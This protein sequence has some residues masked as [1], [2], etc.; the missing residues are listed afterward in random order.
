MLA[1]GL[2]RV[3]TYITPVLAQPTPDPTLYAERGWALPTPTRTPWPYIPPCRPDYCEL[4]E[5]GDEYQSILLDRVEVWRPWVEK[6]NGP[7]RWNQY[8]LVNTEIPV[9]LV[10]AIMLKESR[11]HS[12]ATGC[13][14]E[15]GLFQIVPS[16]AL[17][18][19]ISPDCPTRASGIPNFPER[20]SQYEMRQ[21][22]KNVQMA[23]V[24]LDD[25][26]E[27]AGL[28]LQ[29]RNQEPDGWNGEQ[30]RVATAM[31]QCG[32]LGLRREICSSRGGFAYA[33]DVW[34]CWM[35]FVTPDRAAPPKATSTPVTKY[36]VTP[37][38]T[39]ETGCEA[40]CMDGKCEVFCPATLEPSVTLTP[41]LV[42]VTVNPDPSA[43]DEQPTEE[44]DMKLTRRTHP[45]VVVALGIFLILTL[46]AFLLQADL[47]EGVET[48]IAGIISFLVMVLG[49]KPLKSIYDAIG[50]GGGAVRVVATY[51]VS[52]AIGA[53][54]LF[55][56]GAVS[57]IPVDLDSIL[58][59]GGLLLAAAS[60]AFQRLKDRGAFS[61]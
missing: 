34:E 10:L 25:F 6:Y 51:V 26:Y 38:G 57:G 4:I 7:S 46:S 58:A 39:L 17:Q 48:G 60:V 24:I 29:E 30:G 12:S 37:E 22:H 1:V 40:L 23:L 11:G 50:L 41:T 14:A 55:I 3:Q 19:R 59:L 15:I 49:P 31:F 32:P 2:G 9:N 33:E 28:Y 5:G 21:G 16:D 43:A 8:G 18:V 56:A 27:E 13:A 54:A 35:P 36:L 44:V 20:P 52:L 42:F 47:P 61:A 53:A 45:L